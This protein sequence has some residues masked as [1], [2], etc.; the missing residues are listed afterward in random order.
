MDDVPVHTAHTNSRQM[1]KTI[2]SF[3][4]HSPKSEVLPQ[5]GQWR[6]Q[7]YF[8]HVSTVWL[9]KTPKAR[10]NASSPSDTA[11]HVCPKGRISESLPEHF[12]LCPLFLP[13]LQRSTRFCAK[14]HT[15]TK[16]GSRPLHKQSPTL[17][18]SPMEVATFY[19]PKAESFLKPSNSIQ[20]CTQTHE[21]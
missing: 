16:R 5:I 11:A 17:H 18:I 19:S 13:A 7:N 15:L 8:T 12:H 21:C 9:A 1:F 4:K 10:M 14:A 20:K 2:M 6:K 3:Q